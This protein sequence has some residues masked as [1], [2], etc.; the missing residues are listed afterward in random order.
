MQTR[1]NFLGGLAGAASG[2][3]T[4]SARGSVARAS[5]RKPNLLYII[6]DDHAGYV[7]GA[8]GNRRAITPHLDHL[9]SQG[10]RF[11]A[12]YCNSPVCTPSRQPPHSIVWS[13]SWW[14][15]LLGYWANDRC[16]WI[17]G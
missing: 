13:P 3:L 14:N 17:P 4:R 8:D 7:L 11:A 9:A 6:P 10:T 5:D 12:N 15:Q 2:F 1:R 16:G